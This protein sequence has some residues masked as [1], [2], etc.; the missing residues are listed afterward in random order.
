VQQFEAGEVITSEGAP[1]SGWKVFS[2]EGVFFHLILDGTAEVRKHGERVAAIGPGAYFG[3]LSLI[4]G[5]PRSADVVAGQGGMTTFA[6]P[7]Y[8]FTTLLDKHPEM[9]LPMLRVLAS[10]LRAADS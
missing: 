1:V 8:A 3:E 7:E 6:L 5:K 4:D 2:K 10:R 9:A